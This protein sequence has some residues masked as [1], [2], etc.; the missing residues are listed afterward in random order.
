M[1]HD[2]LL[3][4]DELRQEVQQAIA[5]LGDPDAD[6]SRRHLRAAAE[7]LLAAR[8]VLYAVTIHLLDFLLLDENHLSAWPPSF[9]KGMPLTVTACPPLP[10]RPP[11]HGPQRLPA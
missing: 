9:D 3:N 2:N 4:A 8:E 11:Q 1:S 6:A 5:A 7:R 10:E